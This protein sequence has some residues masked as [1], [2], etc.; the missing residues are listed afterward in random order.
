MHR[1]RLTED[2]TGCA[3]MLTHQGVEFVC[4]SWLL[5]CRAGRAAGQ[6]GAGAAAGAGA[7]GAAAAAK[8][9]RLSDPSGHL[10]WTT[11]SI[12]T[13]A[14]R[15]TG[16][17]CSVTFRRSTCRCD[18]LQSSNPSGVCGAQLCPSMSGVYSHMLV[19]CHATASLVFVPPGPVLTGSIQAAPEG[20]LG[21]LEPTAGRSQAAA[22][23]D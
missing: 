9:D 16:A 2:Y 18:V 12:F 14:W 10:T 21:Q 13:C 11:Q 17:V 20:G 19:C 3:C 4:L 23:A 8:S 1:G 7:G 6:A 22:A 5:G 15:H